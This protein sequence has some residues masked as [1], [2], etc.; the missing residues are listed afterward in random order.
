[1]CIEPA[2]LK[3]SKRTVGKSRLM[4]TKLDKG[5]LTKISFLPPHAPFQLPWQLLI[6]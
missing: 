6:I 5:Q 3:Q 2:A 1:M 4:W